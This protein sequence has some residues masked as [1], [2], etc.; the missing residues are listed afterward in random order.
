GSV[1]TTSATV[2]LAEGYVA[3]KP[4]GS[5][6]VKGLADLVE[7]YEV[8]GAGTARTRLD[9]AAE[10]GLTRFVGRDIELEQLRRAQQLA[11]QGCCQI[12]AIVGEAGVGKSR[13]VREFLH[14]QHTADWLMLESK[15]ASYGQATPYLPVIE[16]LKDYFKINIHDSAKSI[17]ERVIGRILALDASLQDAIPPLLDLLDYLDS[18]DPFRSL[19]LVQRR[20]STYQ[21]VVRLVLAECRVRPVIAVFE[22]LHWNDALSIGLLNELVVAAHGAR[23]LLLVSCRPEYRDE[24]RNRPYDLQLR[25]DSLVGEGL[26]DFLHALLGPDDSLSMLKTFVV[27]R[28]GGNP[29]FIEE[30][31]RSLVDTTV[32]EGIRGNYRLARPFSRTDAPPPAPPAPPSPFSPL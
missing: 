7:I 23:V 6:S 4:L 12:V 28:T 11:A 32:L 25:L 22:D 3:V 1:I 8:T 13:L 5:A 31:V 14:S 15:S 21:A 26:A 18:D 19:D 16:L 20:Q 24:W 29:F 27:E 17:R 30:I 10:R 9:V 2:Q